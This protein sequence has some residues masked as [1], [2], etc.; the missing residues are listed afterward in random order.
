MGI[1]LLL[2]LVHYPHTFKRVIFPRFTTV[3]QLDDVVLLRSIFTTHAS[4]NVVLVCVVWLSRLFAIEAFMHV[5]F[6]PKQVTNPGSQ[7][8]A[9]PLTPLSTADFG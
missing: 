4:G 1:L 7:T 3:H 2:R 9:T 8:N 5:D 6:I